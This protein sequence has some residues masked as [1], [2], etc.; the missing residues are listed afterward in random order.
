MSKHEETSKQV[1]S[2]AARGMRR[3]ESLSLDEIRTVCASAVT[4]RPAKKGL[5]ARVLGK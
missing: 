1:A 3:P 5:L 4:Q 2:I